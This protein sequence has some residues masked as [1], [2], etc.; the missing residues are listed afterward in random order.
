[1]AAVVAAGVVLSGCGLAGGNDETTT[2]PA[3]S[4]TPGNPWD[5][6][7]EQ[8]PALFDPCAEIPVEAVEEGI[9]PHVWQDDE[10]RI[11]R[12]RDLFSCAWKNEEVLF[13]VLST[14]KSRDDYLED[15][16]FVASEF[17]ILGRP[18][19]RLL[20]K[21]DMG[22]NSCQ[23]LFFSGEGTIFVSVDLIHGLASFKGSNFADPCSVLEESIIPV[24]HHLANGDF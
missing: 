21:A 1:M 22:T 2:S 8:R 9:G 20:S 19:L 6:P 14:W 10:M 15:E 13:G 17:E 4:Q 11:D 18:G 12:P 16:S 7:I 23:Q 3:A 24:M 5:L